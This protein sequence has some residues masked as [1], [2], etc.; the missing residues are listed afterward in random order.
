MTGVLASAASTAAAAASAM[1]RAFTKSSSSNC[2]TMAGFGKDL[3][4]AQDLSVTLRT[5][6][7][8]LAQ[9][10]SPPELGEQLVRACG[11]AG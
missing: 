5:P 9:R 1:E 6:K 11:R 3:E 8:R 10:R 7:Y 2:D 4:L